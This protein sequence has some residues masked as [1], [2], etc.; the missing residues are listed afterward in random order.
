MSNPDRD[1]LHLPFAVRR[2]IAGSSVEVHTP[3]AVGAMVA[4]AGTCPFWDYV[5]PAVRA[6][7]GAIAATVRMGVAL[8]GG[9]ASV[10]AT[11]QLPVA[12]I[13][14]PRDGSLAYSGFHLATGFANMCAVAESTLTSIGRKLRVVLL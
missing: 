12:L 6:L 10:C 7:K 1:G 14:Q 2:P 5:G 8:L 3:Q 9:L 11:E 13:A 4:V